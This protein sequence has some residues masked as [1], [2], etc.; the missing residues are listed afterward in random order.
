MCSSFEYR[1]RFVCSMEHSPARKKALEEIII[2]KREDTMRQ[3]IA[4]WC[5]CAFALPAVCRRKTNA[6]VFE[7]ESLFSHYLVRAKEYLTRQ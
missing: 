7:P 2:I 6:F 3:K 5:P 1:Q 4:L